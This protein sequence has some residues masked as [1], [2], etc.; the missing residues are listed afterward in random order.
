[1]KRLRRI[2]IDGSHALPRLAVEVM[3]LR[4]SFINDANF[5]LA[6]QH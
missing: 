4:Q 5:V 2:A 3:A 6:V 1:M